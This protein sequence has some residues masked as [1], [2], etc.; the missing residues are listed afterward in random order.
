MLISVSLSVNKTTNS[1]FKKMPT[2]EN[3]SIRPNDELDGQIRSFDR[4]V[5]VLFPES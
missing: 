4:D 5:K 2:N 1:F 3:A